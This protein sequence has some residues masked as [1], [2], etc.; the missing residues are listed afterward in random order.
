MK[1][2]KNNIGK[3]VIVNG[4]VSGV[5]FNN[6]K[7]TIVNETPIDYSIVFDNY[8]SKLHNLCGVCKIGHGWVIG[9]DRCV[10]FIDK[11]NKKEKKMKT[12]KNT[13]IRIE[14]QKVI[15]NSGQ[16]GYKITY[17]KALPKDKLPYLYI[18]NEYK[19][20]YQVPQYGRNRLVLGNGNEI[21]MG[22]V[23]TEKAF[24]ERIEYCR[25]AGDA[26]MRINKELNELKKQWNGKETIII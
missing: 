12:R 13:G 1:I 6:E 22:C 10:V 2:T 18:T 16:F 20:Y 7:G 4:K 17:V 25:K 26:L 9:K 11:E 21:T 15:M 24:R 5:T 23:Y 19:V 14:A 3:R 8:N